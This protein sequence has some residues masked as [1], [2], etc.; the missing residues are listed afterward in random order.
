MQLAK[1]S[2]AWLGKEKTKGPEISV[3][4]VEVKKRGSSIKGALAANKRG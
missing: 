1:G 3:R 4:Y 2:L